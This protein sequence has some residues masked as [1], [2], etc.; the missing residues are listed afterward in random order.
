MDWG[1][2]MEQCEAARGKFAQLINADIKEIAIVSS[3]SHATSAIATSLPSINDRNE[4]IITDMDFPCIGH[5]WLSQPDIQVNFIPAKKNAYTIDQYE[6]AIY[7][8]TLLTSI[9]HILYY[10][11]FR[12]DIKNISEVVHAKGSYLFVDAYQS[13]GQVD[14][15]VKRDGID[16]L[17]AGMQKYML[18][19]PGIAFMYVR[20][21]LA[22]QLTPG[23]TGWF[24]QAN[25]FAF[26]VQ[27]VKYAGG[28]RRF[29]T[30]TFPM[31][32]GYASNAALDLLHEVG[33]QNIEK[34]L[35]DLSKYTLD[36]A[37]EKGIKIVSPLDPNQKGSNTALLIENAHDVEQKMKE[38]GYIVSARNDVIRIAPH[39]YNTKED[40]IGALD[41][42]KE[43]TMR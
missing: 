26:D 42:F 30:G 36:Y 14:I 9:S 31:L 15:D 40:I 19:I 4:V 38:E 8:N 22:E 3:V 28:A 5:V 34:R 39:F 10:N 23:I 24:G 13:A 11:G 25:P 20:N 12:Q 37:Q 33:I 35:I 29:D 43:I 21:E 7:S 17:V 2:W 18:G 32:N 1:E 6:N 41:C 16:I 27:S